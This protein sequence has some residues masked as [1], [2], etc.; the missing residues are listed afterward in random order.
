MF[1]SA[2]INYV[3]MIVYIYMYMYISLR[4]KS[5]LSQ[6]DVVNE[7]FVIVYIK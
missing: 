6:V 1:T 2:T 4:P 7:K 3:S 5:T